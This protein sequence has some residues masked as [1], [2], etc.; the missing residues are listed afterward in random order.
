MKISMWLIAEKLREYGPSCDIK[1]GRACIEGIRFVAD[2]GGVYEERFVYLC[3]ENVEQRGGPEATDIMLINGEDLILV[4]GQEM[5]SV[6]NS[7]LDVFEYYNRWEASLWELSSRGSLQQVVDRAGEALGNPMILSALDGTVQAMSSAYRDE[8]LNDNWVYCRQTGHLPTAILGAPARTADRRTVQWSDVP[9]ILL[10]PGNIRTIGMM[11]QVEGRAVAAVSL[12]EC[13]TPVTPGHTHLM[14][15]LRDVLCSMYREDEQTSSLRGSVSILTDLLSGNSIDE[16]LLQKVDPR[17]PGPWGLLTV[18]SCYPTTPVTRHSMV[19][20]MIDS[21]APCVPMIFDDG[22]VC[23]CPADRAEA[24]ARDLFGKRELEYYAVV[25]SMPF[26]ALSDL[27]TRY[28]QN[29]FRMDRNENSPGLFF[30]VDTGMAF[31]LSRLSGAGDPGALVHP[32]LPFLRAYD[33]Q[34][35]GDLYHSLYHYLLNERSIQKGAEAVHVHRNSFLYRLRRIQSLWPV[36]LDDPEVRGY[37]LLSF[38][39]EQR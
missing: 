36:D 15:V 22:V 1:L 12:W 16:E 20:Q 35:G 11:L 31:A 26:E 39:L 18:E 25:V 32:L 13:D 37:L 24:F 30:A 9:Q 34:N 27:R 17:C 14:A 21:P 7:L 2:R 38:W 10:L 3:T 6:L 5:E 23:L 8:D 29:R 4:R 33:A 28:L 19:R